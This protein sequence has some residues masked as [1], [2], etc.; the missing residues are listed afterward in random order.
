MIIIKHTDSD[1]QKEQSE[2][3]FSFTLP[4]TANVLIKNDDLRIKG[5][6]GHELNCLHVS[7]SQ[8]GWISTGFETDGKS[9]L[10]GQHLLSQMV[11]L[12]R[13]D[14]AHLSPILPYV[15]PS[16]PQNMDLTADC[17]IG[18]SRSTL[19]GPEVKAMNPDSCVLHL[20]IQKQD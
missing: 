12:Q 2:T 16:A 11:T 1:E 13:L 10:G 17:I 4:L 19:E 9:R 5:M 7:H 3:S 8:L 18:R 14:T 20:G 15:H 6:F